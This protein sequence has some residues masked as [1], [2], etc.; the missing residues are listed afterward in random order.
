MIVLIR[1]RLV[2]N[3][4][5]NN[6]AQQISLFDIELLKHLLYPQTPLQQ[7]CPPWTSLPECLFC[8]LLLSFSWPPSSSHTSPSTKGKLLVLLDHIVAIKIQFAPGDVFS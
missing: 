7:V 4:Q 1:L 3:N 5:D 2:V 6:D 8:S